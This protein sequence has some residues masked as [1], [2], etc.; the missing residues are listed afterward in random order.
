M[1]FKREKIFYRHIEQRILILVYRKT[2]LVDKY[3]FLRTAITNL[4]SRIETF[5]SI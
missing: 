1:I 4:E 2:I 3:F 5:L